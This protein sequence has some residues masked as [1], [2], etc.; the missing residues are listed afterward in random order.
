MTINNSADKWDV[1]DSQVLS[2]FFQL[3]AKSSLNLLDGSTVRNTFGD[4]ASTVLL[5]ADSSIFVQDSTF[6]ENGAKTQTEF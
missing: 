2:G 4:V 5:Q 1:S 3:T 6:I